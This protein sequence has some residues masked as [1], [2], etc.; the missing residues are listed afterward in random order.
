[1]R[2]VLI[3]DVHV[4]QWWVPPWALLGKPLFGQ[5]NLWFNRGRHIDLSLLEPTFQHAAGL[6]PDVALFS[7]DLT[8]TARTREFAQVAAAMRRYFSHVPAL[9]V[10]G[11]HDRYTYTSVL[12][13]RMQR[14]LGEMTPSHFPS[15][16]HLGGR[17]HWLAMNAARPSMFNA[18]GLVGKA[19][20]DEVARW[21]S[22]L[23][24]RDGVIAVC[25]YPYALP[26]GVQDRASHRLEDADAVAKLFSDCRARVVYL[27]GHIH[28]PWVWNAKGANSGPGAG[29]LTINA[30]AP[31]LRNRRHPGGQGF[32]QI[33]LPDE[34]GGRIDLTRHRVRGDPGDTHPVW[35][36]IPVSVP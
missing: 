22:S 17:W 21:L 18:R 11:N 36:V 14:G 33:D 15:T 25:H 20:R 27:H 31:L 6:K 30:G 1:M 9:A 12:R 5:L 26:E 29:V 10:P 28:E 3:G 24:Q 19:Q 2:L 8:T 23:T 4:Y 32:W 7:G 13:R 34:V 16:R 35:D